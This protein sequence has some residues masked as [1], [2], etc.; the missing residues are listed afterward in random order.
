MFQSPQR[1][2]GGLNTNYFREIYENYK[3]E[4]F[5][6]AYEI[7][8]NQQDAED[9]IHETFVTLLECPGKIRKNSPEK[10]WNYILT[11]V[12]NKS[13]NLI[14]RRKYRSDREFVIEMLEDVMDEAVDGKFI[15]MEQK[16]FVMEAL[17]QMNKTY[18][19]ILILQYY[20]E[21]SIV[22]IARLFGKTP[23]NIRHLSVRAKRKLKKLLLEAKSPGS[24]QSTKQKERKMVI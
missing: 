10:N 9:V 16:E 3:D 23:D 8:H 6:A 15:Q 11:I 5:Y 24:C 12:K 18:R 19:D 1:K 14:K 13:Y 22:E 17:R 7:L 21:M 2:N 20:H 4:M